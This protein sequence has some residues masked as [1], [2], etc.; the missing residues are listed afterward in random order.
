MHF[1]SRAITTAAAIWLT[2]PLLAI[3]ADKPKVEVLTVTS[4]AVK[5]GKSIPVENS[6]EGKDTAPDLSWSKAPARAKSIAITCEDPDAPGGTWFHWILFNL[7]PEA[8]KLAA[9]TEK[10]ASLPGGVGQ[11]I[12]DFGKV[13]YNGPMPPKGSEHHYQFKVFALDTKLDLKPECNKTQFYQALSGHVI[14]RG[15]L[16]GLYKRP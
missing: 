14:G 4:S 13:G 1:V 3:A 16:T 9:G 15:K 5:E 7:E 2:M 12:N 8:T 11:G 6:G 10:K